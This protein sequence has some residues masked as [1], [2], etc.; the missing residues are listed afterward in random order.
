M[1]LSVGHSE[2]LTILHTQTVLTKTSTKSEYL[3]RTAAA[4]NVKFCDALII[5][6]EAEI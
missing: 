1:N 6:I 2:A 3:K 5:T 4:D